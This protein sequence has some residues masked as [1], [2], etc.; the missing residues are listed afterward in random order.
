MK[1]RFPVNLVCAGAL[2]LAACGVCA[3]GTVRGAVPLENTHWTLTWVDGTA[4]KGRSPRQAYID[5]DTGSHRMSGF[6]GCNQLIGTYQLHGDHL[7]LTG[8]ERTLMA[9]AGGMDSEDKLV[10]ALEQVREWKI[11]DGELELRDDAGNDVA[12]FTA[13]PPRQ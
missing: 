12:R 6:G 8:T 7:R 10:K 4:V 2:M 3:Q 1:I 13:A 11:S 9:C 5:L